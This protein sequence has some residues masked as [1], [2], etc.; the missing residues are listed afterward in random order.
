MFW[1]QKVWVCQT[2]SLV[3]LRLSWNSEFWKPFF[4]NGPQV[5][6]LLTQSIWKH[7]IELCFYTWYLINVHIQGKVIKQHWN[8]LWKNAFIIFLLLWRLWYANSIGQK[9]ILLSLL[10]C[11]AIYSFWPQ[12]IRSFVHWL[13]AL[14]SDNVA[15]SFSASA[16]L[17]FGWLVHVL[18]CVWLP[19]CAFLT[20]S[21]SL[22]YRIFSSSFVHFPPLLL[23]RS[24][25]WQAAEL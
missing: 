10:I 3:I 11:H 18:N 6:N 22:F 23:L 21:S 16:Q 17:V 12:S 1:K 24:W 25:D 4:W 9:L 2:W 5:W 7:G 15:S 14:I 19:L 20:A 13:N 8:M